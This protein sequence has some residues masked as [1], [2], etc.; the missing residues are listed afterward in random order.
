MNIKGVNFGYTKQ[1][2]KILEVVV[3]DDLDIDIVYRTKFKY[4]TRSGLFRMY[5]QTIENNITQSLHES[6][7][8]QWKDVCNYIKETKSIFK[9]VIITIS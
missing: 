5:E 6:D 3:L 7:N 2:F 4:K 8:V 1:D 9:K